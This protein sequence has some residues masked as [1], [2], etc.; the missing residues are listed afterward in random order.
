LMRYK[1]VELKLEFSLD[2]WTSF[3]NSAIWNDIVN[4]SSNESSHFS[5]KNSNTETQSNTLSSC[6]AQE[7]VKHTLDALNNSVVK[8]SRYELISISK[9]CQEHEYLLSN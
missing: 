3:F 8:D 6:A 1:N 4:N 7:T 5:T 2:N 9:V